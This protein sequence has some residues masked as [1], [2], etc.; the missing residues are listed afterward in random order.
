MDN[1]QAAF[2]PVDP[3]SGWSDT[4]FRSKPVNGF[5]AGPALVTVITNGIPSE[6]KSVILTSSQP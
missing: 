6:A 5:P 4:A 3:D 1:S 2:L